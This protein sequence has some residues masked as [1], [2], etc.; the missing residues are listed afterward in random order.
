MKTSRGRTGKEYRHEKNKI[1]CTMGPT[2]A[3]RDILTK[4]VQAGMNAARF[5]FSHG[6]HEEHRGNIDLVKQVRQEQNQPIALMLDTKGP[7]YRIGTFREKQVTLVAGESFTLTA[8]PVEGDVHQ[9]SVSCPDMFQRL[10]AGDTIL[11][12]DGL[13]SV[14]VM[15]RDD[16]KA[17]CQVVIGG[18]ISNNKSMSFPNKVL[19]TTYL[20]QQDKEDLLF[21]I[22]MDV[23]YVAASFI[24]TAQDVKDLRRFLDENGGEQ[25][26]IIA[27]I[28]NQSGVDHADVIL[29]Y[30]GGIMVAR[31]DLWVEI[32]YE[33]L[34]PIQKKLIQLC[35]KRGKFVITTTEM[36]ESMTGKPRPTRAEISDVANAVYDGSSAVMISGETA[37]G[38]YPVEAVS[39]MRRIVERTEEHISYEKRFHNADY[40]LYDSNDAMSHGACALAIDTGAA[41]MVV[42]TL[43]GNMARQVSRFRCPKPIIGLT[44][45]QKVWNQLALAWNVQP[46]MSEQFPSVDVLLYYAQQ[47]AKQS[48]LVASGDRVIIT[49]GITNGTSGN[50]DLIKMEKIE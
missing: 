39:A 29:D 3:K 16:A 45:N 7:E 35:L 4:M 26:D 46:A 17:V 12:N 8:E 27:K 21:G 37:A 9:V 22:Q 36:L 2:C 47:A 50:T 23:D 5:N 38:S 24:S 19:H 18:V 32:P 10:S 28:E 34:P 14:Q 48:G 43:S 44:T 41:A 30:C 20:S 42:C 1:I 15:E 33:E 31:G 11:I 40:P 13:V 6:S 49:A 25:I